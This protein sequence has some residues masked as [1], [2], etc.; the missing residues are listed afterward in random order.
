M[1]MELKYS[2]IINKP[3]DEVV[4]I[5]L[6]LDETPNYTPGLKSMELAEGIL[7]TENSV[8][9]LDY[10]TAVVRTRI[11]DVHLPQMITYQRRSGKNTITTKHEFRE[12]DDHVHYKM[13]F[14]VKS[15]GIR[16]LL[17][18]MYK[19]RL[20]EDIEKLGEKFKDYVESV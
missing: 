1:N 8:Y 12:H 14:E 17:Q 15:K 7:H 19:N 9:I 6:D 2:T 3:I 13:T 18:K 4:G 16:G 5:L 11:I 10:G 20:Q